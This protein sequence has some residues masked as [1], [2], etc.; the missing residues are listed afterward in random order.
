MGQQQYLP[1]PRHFTIISVMWAL[2]IFLGL[3]SGGLAKTT[4]TEFRADRPGLGCN[5][6]CSPLTFQDRNGIVHGNCLSISN[7]ARWCYVDP[8]YQECED[9]RESQRFYN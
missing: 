6:Q 9:L 7:G 2:L 1:R 3:I 4:V 8:R 5:C